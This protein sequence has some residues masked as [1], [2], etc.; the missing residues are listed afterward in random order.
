M[1]QFNDDF[2]SEL[3]KTI[4]DIEN[5]SLVEIVA[6]VRKNSGNYRDVSLFFASVVSFLIVS[7]LMF[8]EFIID[9]Y[10]IY[11]IALASFV[12][13]YLIC[14]LINPLK[15]LLIR[16]KRMNRNVEIYGR[17]IFQKGGIRFTGQKTG[18]LI[19]LSVFEKQVL[20]LPDRGA[21]TAVPDE[22]WQTLNNNFQTVFNRKDIATAFIK[23]LK[24]SGKI[25]AEYI[26]PAENDINE[27]PDDLEVDL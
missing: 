23:E 14:E 20:I 18:V 11:F 27:L 7:W 19:F 2:K 17:A 24:N 15:R 13:L 16:K 6:A 8:A 22:E 5:K 4:E 10:H 9:V 21:L 26:L 25:F 1:K 12:L 3:Y